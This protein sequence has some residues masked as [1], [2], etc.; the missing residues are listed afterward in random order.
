MRDLVVLLALGLSACGGAT[1]PPA[2]PVAPAPPPK[3]VSPPA[4]IEVT[5]DQLHGPV[6]SFAITGGEDIDYLRLQPL[7]NDEVGKPLERLRLRQKLDRAMEA[8]TLSDLELRGEQLADGVKLLV[9]VTPQPKVVSIALHDK[10]GKDLAL[11]TALATAKG[12]R[13]SPADLDA[14]VIAM[15]DE[16]A[17]DGQVGYSATWNAVHVIGGVAVTIE[18][19][20][21]ERLVIA[22]RTFDGTKLVK[23]AE[24]E[25]VLAKDAVVGGPWVPDQVDRATLLLMGYYWDH[26]FAEV[27]I[28]PTPQ[29]AH[30]P[31]TLT[32]QINEG[33]IFHLGRIEMTGVP[34]ADVKRFLALMK[35]KTGALFN[36]TQIANARGLVND[37][38]VKEGH[39]K[40]SVVPL[41][42]VDPA[43][44]TVDFSF[45]VTLGG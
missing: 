31:A 10:D 7:L 37:T 12:A 42:K 38:L 27:N 3:P 14:V 9:K 32:F 19:N 17:N 5:W 11:P 36:R 24:L 26:G 21:G 15:R 13:L 33:P 40:A 28:H 2:K 39:P 23:K 22:A 25:R 35:L 29:P 44:N 30:G 1:P 43:K 8:Q 20:P 6:R 18:T 41:T 4:P 45:E 16:L 34:P